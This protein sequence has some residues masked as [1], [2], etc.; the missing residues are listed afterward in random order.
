VFGGAE[1]KLDSKEQKTERLDA[2]TTVKGKVTL[3]SNTKFDGKYTVTADQFAINSLENILDK[4]KAI[5]GVTDARDD[6]S[7]KDK[8]GAL[9][10]ILKKGLTT[11]DTEKVV[12]RVDSE[13]STSKTFNQN[14]TERYIDDKGRPAA[15]VVT[16]SITKML[17]EW[18]KWRTELEKKACTYWIGE[19]D[20]AIRRLELLMLAVDNR[21][22]IIE[23][24]DREGDRVELDTWLAKKLKISVDEAHFIYELRIFQL[25]KLERKSLEAQKKEVLAHKKGLEARRKKPEPHMA[26]QLD[27]F[28]KLVA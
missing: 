25:R 18:V 2:F 26:K 10:V 24:L 7:K 14:R 6:S 9:T 8:F 20:K 22:L 19:D 15:R 28:A 27:E 23:S 17:V 4:L 3:W 13:L 12:R 5:P 1:R 16:M 21:K 11:K